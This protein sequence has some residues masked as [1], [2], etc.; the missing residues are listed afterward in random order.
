MY[1]PERYLNLHVR[2][3]PLDF[4]S[5]K[6][7]EAWTRAGLSPVYPLP[8]FFPII[9]LFEVGNGDLTGFY[10]PIGKEDQEPILC[11]TYH[12][13]WSL[14]PQASSLE[15]L[16]RRKV[17]EGHVEVE[18]DEDGEN[19]DYEGAREI[20]EQLG[21][22]LLI[23]AAERASPQLQLLL[24]PDSPVAL[25]SAAAEAAKARDVEGAA[26]LLEHSLRVLPEYSEALMMLG[27]V[28]RRQG[29]LLE[30]AAKLVEALGAPLCLGGDR[31]KALQSVKRLRDEDYP[32][33]LDDPLWAQRQRLTLV[34]GVKRNDDLLV[35][36]KAIATYLSQGKGI[37]AVRLRMLV[38][39][40]MWSETVSFRER[41]NY[42][43]ERHRQLLRD[44]IERAGLTARLVALGSPTDSGSAN[45][46]S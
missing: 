46:S 18:D 14:E 31:Q 36:E 12:D 35:Y 42:T 2:G 22:S 38:G 43:F 6:Q 8:G 23:S 9:S 33:L 44:E 32:E 3:Y 34:T 5:A 19:D 28:Y 29:R 45:R 39:E 17:A 20:A 40:L 1:V 13:N 4:G 27:N 30:A 11:D 16:I 25:K 26:G 21:V 37:L 15:G 41:Y 10:W 7:P 24:D